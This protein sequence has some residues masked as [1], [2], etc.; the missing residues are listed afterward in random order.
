MRQVEQAEEI[1]RKYVKGP[2]R[3]RHHG[4]LARIEVDAKLL[5]VL[6]IPEVAANINKEIIALGF[7]YVTFDLAGYKTGSLNQQ[8]ENI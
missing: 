4:V 2:V 8:L 5:G 3:V 7:K 1:I 6:A